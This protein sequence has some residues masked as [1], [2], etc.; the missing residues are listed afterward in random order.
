[1]GK[2][3][4]QQVMRTNRKR[5]TP[6]KEDTA[7]RVDTSVDH[8]AVMLATMCEIGCVETIAVFVYVSDNLFFD[9]L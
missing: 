2:I 1:M 6:S 7:E 3:K 8:K 5:K 9:Q 4:L